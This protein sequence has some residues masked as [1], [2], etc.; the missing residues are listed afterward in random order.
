MTCVEF[1]RFL[2]EIIEQENLTDKQA[3]LKECSSC[4]TLV[5]DLRV[6]SH[7]A[8]LL[9][10]SDEPNPRVWNRIEIALR[11]EGLIRDAHT[12]STRQ[13]ESPSRWRLAWLVPAM[14]ALLLSIGF[15]KHQR[16]SNTAQS[17][18]I[19]T[20]EPTTVAT[21]SD[22]SSRF[23]DQELLQEVSLRSPAMRNS[24]GADLENVNAY[25]RDAET[26]ARSNPNDE[27]AQR[28]VINAYEQKAMIYEMALD[29]PLQ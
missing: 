13:L 1:E 18:S 27:A 6:I 29:R 22:D 12:E 4:S 25:I 9:Q 21:V 11:Q 19:Q 8:R 17:P 7:E 24:Y 5:S 2:P 28:Y 3:H 26:A 20:N 23:K 14:A 10:E 15:L 16:D